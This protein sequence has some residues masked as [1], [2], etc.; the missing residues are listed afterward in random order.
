MIGE[1][2]ATV[3]TTA[4]A[5]ATTAQISDVIQ[6]QNIGGN[7][8]G[9]I[10]GLAWG[11]LSNM[12][13]TVLS[14]NISSTN[15]S[16]SD[17]MYGYMFRLLAIN[18]FERELTLNMISKGAYKNGDPDGLPFS[19]LIPLYGNIVSDYP[20]FVRTIASE[21]LDGD[22]T[23]RIKDIDSKTNR[24]EAKNLFPD[25]L[26]IGTFTD[27]WE[28]DNRNSILHK[29][30]KLFEEGKINT[31]IS[32]FGTK[33][34]GGS[35]DIDFNG[36]V[37]YED[38]GMSRGKNLKRAPSDKPYDVNGYNNPYC[39]VWTHHHQYEKFENTIRPF[40]TNF[41][42]DKV[43]TWVNK[44]DF[45]ENEDGEW[46]WKNGNPEWNHSVLKQQDG[47]V[48]ITPKYDDKRSIHTKDC[49][50]SIENLAWKDYN[51]YEFEN[52]L[53][54]EQRG[55]LGGR[56][57]WFPPYGI[58]FTENTNVQ[59]NENSFIGRG[60]KVY[61][62]TDTT[63][64]GTLSFM[65]LTDHPSIT[66]YVS[67]SP[68]NS[69]KVDDDMWNRFFAGCDSLNGDE[70]S[71]LHFVTPTPKD[72]V[73]ETAGYTAEQKLDS[74]EYVDET[75]ALDEITFFVFFPNYYSGFG[76]QNLPLHQDDSDFVVGYLLGGVNAQKS[77]GKT[78]NDIPVSFNNTDSDGFR[79]GY[80]MDASNGISDE[81]NMEITNIYS[82]LKSFEQY[83]E[84]DKEYLYNDNKYWKYRVD[85][86][87]EVAKGNE[88]QKNHYAKQLKQDSYKDE[89]SFSLNRDIANIVNNSLTSDDQN[90]YSFA[91]FAYAVAEYKNAQGIKQFLKEKL[92]SERQ[93]DINALIGIVKEKLE[94]ATLVGYANSQGNQEENEILAE[95]RA[96]TI[97]RWLTNTFGEGF[98]HTIESSVKNID[99]GNDDIN[100][101]QAKQWRSV[102]CVL[103]FKKDGV[104]SDVVNNET[105]YSVAT[106]TGVPYT[107]VKAELIKNGFITKEEAEKLTGSELNY[108]YNRLQAQKNSR[109]N[110]QTSGTNKIRYD[111]E[112]YFYKKFQ[113]DNPFVWKKLTEKLQYFD[114]AFHSMTP[115]GFNM[116]LTFLQQCTRQGNT[117]SASDTTS[118]TRVASNMAFGRPPFCVLRLGDFFNQMI[119]IKSINVVYDEDGALTWDLNSEGIGAQPMIARVTITFDFI[120][121]SDLAGPVR[122]LQNAMTFNYYANA[123]LYDNRA[124]RMYYEAEE[125]LSTKMG[126]AGND[127]PLL[128]KVNS[129]G[130]IIDKKG[131]YT[132]YN[133]ISNYN[134]L[135]DRQQERLNELSNSATEGRMNSKYIQQSPT[136]IITEHDTPQG[137]FPTQENYK[138][139]RGYKGAD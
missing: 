43:H 20:T 110:G 118:G 37:G 107:Q 137:K 36:K 121:G 51:P 120:G 132:V 85:G 111:N 93:D 27:K 41:T 70:D 128:P 87:Y 52:A 117:I 61:T 105:V 71:L 88:I 67:W 83:N 76:S 64:S 91:E 103:K 3:G 100:D 44:F 129:E 46:G 139:Q 80:E 130:R 26:G 112:M 47:L 90:L 18:K 101:I 114:P 33:V 13:N 98:Q 58:S 1:T 2:I 60:E 55:P 53:S 14:L 124:D 49:M 50:F 11:E 99:S 109:E 108:L 106:E 69:D 138:R 119:V 75:D 74:P 127:K 7:I 92:S 38:T 16:L 34:D 40:D 79:K 84:Y 24:I 102:K 66:D 122:R 113:K 63:R 116:R 30:K 39:R 89:N 17:R 123:S 19:A 8:G 54:W 45:N 125:N 48:N 28:V 6:R 72:Y 78:G 25:D 12:L 57:M 94:E 73:F 96:K 15:P 31:L 29:T 131:S 95:Q 134:P 42:M 133:T 86:K 22:D 68:E 56:I 135:I 82:S 9:S 136:N 62:Y 4:M 10:Y 65:M 126:G 32:R 115:E 35:N 5:A 77:K 81:E 59:W 104:A 97:L 21:E 23:T